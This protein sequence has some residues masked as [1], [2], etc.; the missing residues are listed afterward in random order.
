MVMQL[1][2]ASEE[3][4]YTHNALELSSG[5]HG[6]TRDFAHNVLSQ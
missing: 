3:E 1:Q 2:V 4:V 6:S 5:C